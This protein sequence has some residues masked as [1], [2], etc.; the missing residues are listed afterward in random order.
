MDTPELV[1]ALWGPEGVQGRGG[2]WVVGAYTQLT[3]PLQEAGALS[4]IRVA[5][6]LGS[7]APWLAP[8]VAANPL[9]TELALSQVAQRALRRTT[10]SVDTRSGILGACGNILRAA[11]AAC[12]AA[13]EVALG[14]HKPRGI[15]VGS[16]K[17]RGGAGQGSR[18]MRAGQSTQ[19]AQAQAGYL[20]AAMPTAALSVAALCTAAALG[21]L[22]RAHRTAQAS[23]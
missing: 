18:G 23:S 10:H 22:W 2:I 1:S 19:H 7:P 11:E 3:V 14:A 5:A 9:C 8:E 21:Y 16:L 17:E 13:V 20:S 12:G 6:A 4:A 15:P